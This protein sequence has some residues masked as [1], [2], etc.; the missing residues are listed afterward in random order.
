M[1]TKMIRLFIVIFICFG[2]ASRAE[3]VSDTSL[4]KLL[5]VSGLMA[6]MSEISGMILTGIEQSNRQGSE[7]P[8]AIMGHLYRAVDDAFAAEKILAAVRQ[9]LQ[10]TMTESQVQSL[11]TW[12]DSEIGKRI[13]QAEVDAS[14]PA[15]YLEMNRI[16]QSLFE[17]QQRVIIAQSIAQLAKSTDMVMDLQT[18]TAVAVYA[19]VAMAINP[20]EQVDLEAFRQQMS[21]REELM[22]DNVEQFV[23]LS[24]LYS[25]R[26]I[27]LASMN[28]YLQFLGSERSSAFI[29]SVN[30]GLSSGMNQA[31]ANM[32]KL[33]YEGLSKQ[34]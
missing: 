18:N 17:D 29:D 19:A 32:A 2:S 33:L 25:Y 4:D 6:Q 23:V 24:L 16:G 13:V 34:A 30:T 9:E 28:E 22:R 12:Y 11:L 26:D 27:D 14:S 3:Q 31:I 5:D 21:S 15:A 7:V 1:K 20:G 10:K 8:D